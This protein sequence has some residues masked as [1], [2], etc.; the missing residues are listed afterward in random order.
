MDARA[1]TSH[2]L[3]GS[4]TLSAAEQFQGRESSNL[5]P[6][7]ALA[8][9]A[10]ARRRRI[11]DRRQQRS[12]EVSHEV[13]DKTF[14]FRNHGSNRVFPSLRRLIT[15]AKKSTFSPWE[16][17]E[18]SRICAEFLKPKCTRSTFRCNWIIWAPVLSF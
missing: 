7:R 9:Q 1:Q 15:P 14:L 13:V 18:R 16:K 6:V 12:V 10:F 4:T 8:N 5:S 11:V 3:K 17:A 2:G